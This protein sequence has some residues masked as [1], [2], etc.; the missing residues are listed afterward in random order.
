MPKRALTTNVFKSHSFDWWSSP[1]LYPLRALNQ[2]RVPLVRDQLITKSIATDKPLSGFKLVDVGCGGGLL[3]E[4]LARLGA[5]VIGLDSSEESLSVAQNHLIRYSPSLREKLQYHNKSIEQFAAE[6][7]DLVDAVVA[8]E[9]VE[10]VQDLDSFFKNC[11]KVLKPHGLVVITTINQTLTAY[12][13]D[14]LLAEKVFRILP[15]GTH[16]YENFVSPTSLSLLLE[17]SK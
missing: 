16:Q 17:E 14:I 12:V 6:C 9:V 5:S 4:P 7:N 11:A 15:D 10:H 1:D 8:S 13:L 2:L 3:S